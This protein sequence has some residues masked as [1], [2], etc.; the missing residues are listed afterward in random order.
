MHESGK[1]LFKYFECH[2]ASLLPRL[3]CFSVVVPHHA[4]NTYEKYGSG[5]GINAVEARAKNT[6]TF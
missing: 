6:A 2:D 5:L 1:L 4:K 3:G